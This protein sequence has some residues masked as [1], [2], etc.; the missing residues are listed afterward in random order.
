LRI[1]FKSKTTRYIQKVNTMQ[2]RNAIICVTL[3]LVAAFTSISAVNAV[4][5]LNGQNGTTLS[6]TVTAAGFMEHHQ[7]YDWT[8][9]KTMMPSTIEVD[10]NQVGQVNAVLTAT[11]QLTTEYDVY[12]VAGTVTVL[13]GGAVATQNLQVTVVVQY[14]VGSGQFQDLSTSTTTLTLPGELQAGQTGTYEYRIDYTPIANVQYKV[15]AYITITNHSGH[16]ATV[17]GPE[18]KADYTLPTSPTSTIKVDDTAQL[19]DAAVSP[20]G[21][22]TQTSSTGPWQLT[23]S[24]TINYV[25]SITNVDA[26]YDQYSQLLNTATLTQQT[27][28]QQKTAQA[29]VTI[30]SGPAPPTTTPLT[31]GYW[32]THAG[33]TGNN[34][35]KVTAYLPIYLGTAGGTRSIKVTTPNDVVKVLEM[36]T[37]GSASNGITKLYAQLLAVKLNIAN[38]AD[39]SKISGIINSADAFLAGK[40]YNS[41]SSLDG[42]SKA[43][44]LAMM[45]TLDLYNNGAL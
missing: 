18:P 24:T 15:V 26:A 21:Y 22:T 37:Y 39:S 36:K 41:W 9:T 1:R 6:A 29:Q 28:Q 2:S 17:F 10:R 8:L 20:I 19:T 16:L 12:G 14:K 32:K 45:N 43:T 4:P 31:I 3:L 25:V 23:D 34:G 38:G 5:I 11:R 40:D 33:F 42:T 7:I 13:N 44:V 30:Y 35:D 27:T